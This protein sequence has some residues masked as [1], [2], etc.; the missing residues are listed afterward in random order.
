MIPNYFIIGYCKNRSNRGRIR[1]N[2]HHY[3]KAAILNF[4]VQFVFENSIIAGLKKNVSKQKA[5]PAK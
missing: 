3:Q 1:Y 2:Y 5:S 4:Y